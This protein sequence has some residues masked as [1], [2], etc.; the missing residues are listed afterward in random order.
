MGRMNLRR[1]TA[2][3]PLQMMICRQMVYRRTDLQK[4]FAST[5]SMKT[6]VNRFVE[7][8]QYTNAEAPRSLNNYLE[9]M[10]R[11]E[12]TDATQFDKSL[13]GFNAK[14][15]I[16]LNDGVIKDFS[17]KRQFDNKRDA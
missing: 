16:L 11:Y 8:N 15:D 4:H 3:L 2:P 12:G 10:K 7:Q 17:G 6:L 5:D 9:L 14:L 1:W 13:R